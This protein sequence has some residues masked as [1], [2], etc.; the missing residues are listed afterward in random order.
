MILFLLFCHLIEFLGIHL[1]KN[2][3]KNRM[4]SFLVGSYDTNEQHIAKFFFNHS[5]IVTRTNDRIYRSLSFLLL[6]SKER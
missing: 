6:I 5:Y 1:M 4:K 3:F 2:F